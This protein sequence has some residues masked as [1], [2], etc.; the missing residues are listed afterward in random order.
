MKKLAA[1]MLALLLVLQIMPVIAGDYVA[2]DGYKP[3]GAFREQLEISCDSE[4]IIV[5]ASATLS[6]TQGYDNLT[7]KSSKEDIAT[8][9]DGVVTGVASGTVKITAK[10]GDFSDAIIIRVIAGTEENTGTT[11]GMETESTED[12]EKQNT[13]SNEKMIIVVSTAKEKRTYDGQEHE[14]GFTAKA[15]NNTEEFD[16]AKVKINPD[17]IV[18]AKDCGITKADYTAA[19]FTYEGSDDVVF[20]VSEGWIQIKPVEATVKA[21][22]VTI[23]EDDLATLELTATVTGVIE[24]EELDYDL[25]WPEENK[26]GEYEIVPTG[27]KQQGNYNVTFEKGKLTITESTLAVQPLYNLAKIGNDYY[28]LAKS[29]IRTNL[30]INKNYKK[31][32]TAEEYR[33]DDYD[34]N[35]LIITRNDKTYLYNCAENADEI[36]KGA[37]YYDVSLE[38]VEIVQNKIGGLDNNKNPR[39]LIPE[40]QRYDDPNTTDSIHRNYIIKLTDNK[41]TREEQPLY[42]MVSVDGSKNYHRLKRTTII[43]KPAE[44]LRA[45]TVLN[46]NEYLMD[47]YDF[48]N[49]TINTNGETYKYSPTKPTGLYD[50]CFTIE[51]ENVKKEDRINGS[52]SWYNNDDGWL[53]NSRY[54][55][56]DYGEDLPRTTVGYHANYKATTYKGTKPPKSVKIHSTWPNGKLAFD[57]AQITLEGEVEGFDQGYTLQWQYSADKEKWIDIPGANE[58]NYTYTLTDETENLY[59]RL[60][61]E[62]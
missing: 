6:H 23:S 22:D 18:K 5:G 35:D 26:A 62:D 7:W 24:G 34:F 54:Q 38:K 8:V 55:Y 56:G 49:V 36:F 28:R 31:I 4:V 46:Q 30:V 29:E 39:W 32:L 19:D 13:V 12:N 14:V 10:E 9:E 1:W 57:G 27:D 51:F 58:L 11:E 21:D 48:S 3:S 44:G 60:V 47:R 50:S 43:A 37:N 20:E 52:D 41:V 61:A 15:I 42:N 53:D 40:E 17:R 45:G 2:S 16:V 33:A 25:N 59:W